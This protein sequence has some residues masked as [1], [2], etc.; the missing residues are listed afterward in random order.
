MKKI[1]YVYLIL[2]INMLTFT[3]CH[4]E[5]MMDTEGVGGKGELSLSSLKMDVNLKVDSVYLGSRSQT[6]V[7]FSQYIVS[8]YNSQ[9]QQVEQWVYREMPEIVSLEVGSYT[10]T[11]TSSAEQTSGFDAPYYKGS[12]SFDI[13]KDKVTEVPTITCSL[14]NML[15][16]VVYD[17]DF[18]GLLGEDVVTT[19]TIGENSLDIP[20]SETRKAYLATPSTENISM[21]VTLKGTIDGEAIDYSQ[22]FENVKAGVHNVIR[23]KFDTV[24]G[25]IPKEGSL[26]VS[27]GIDSSLDGSDEVIGVDPG[28]EP[29]IDDFPTDGEGG[30]TEQNKPSI[31]GTDFNGAAFDI[32]N[33]VLSIPTTLEGKM[34]LTVTLNAPNGI[35]HVYVT[36]D[37]ETLT[38]A[39]LTDVG[40]K[41][42]FDLAEPGDLEE[43]LASLGFPV[44]SE[45][46]GQK[47]IPF[48]ITEFTPLLGIYG[49][50][51][52]NF[53]IRLVDQKGL[54]VTQTLKIKS[55]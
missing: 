20:V 35:A 27:I 46:I 22:R 1:F 15:F 48:S 10:I 39:V 38:E 29:D 21:T 49:A 12:T 28:Q 44:G 2:L 54:E 24:N 9:S 8:I 19:V 16:T 36:I 55:V 5:S 4:N 31:V 7:D 51:S 34:P 30:D 25:D 47:T 52:H 32:E 17:E 42:S 14:A 3:A 11:V 26:N 43:G 13:Q 37:S 23:Y 45:I 41:K 6:S 40:L 50:A 33:D 53:I 18:E